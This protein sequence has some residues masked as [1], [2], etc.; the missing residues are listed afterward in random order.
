LKKELF[1]FAVI[2]AIA[3]AIAGCST[4]TPASSPGTAK[5]TAT[6]SL[7]KPQP[8]YGG[9]LKFVQ[10]QAPGTP[11]GWPPD[12]TAPA[13]YTQQM[14]L[15]YLL[16]EELDGVTLSPCLAESY[17]L[18]TDI[19]NPSVIFNIRKGVKFHDGSSLNADVVKWNL[20]RIKEN[21]VNAATTEAWKSFDMIDEYTLRVNFNG[22]KNFFLRSFTT[23]VTPIAS[24][25]AFEKNGLDYV[26]WNMVGTGPFK[27]ADFQRDV[28]AKTVKFDDY[29]EKGKPYLS[30][31]DYVYVTDSTTRIAL[32]KS[33]GA[34]IMDL[35]SD[36]R[37]AN[38]LKTTGYNIAIKVDQ[39]D[40]LFPDSKNPD[41]PWA[42]LKVRM[43]AEYAINKEALAKTFGYGFL[44]AA[45]QLPVTVSS[46]FDPTIP[47]R[48]YDL[49]KAKQLLSEA[50]YPNG[51]D[52]KI[53]TNITGNT[54]REVAI[55]SDLA[56]IGIK[57]EL[58]VNEQA[59]YTQLRSVGWKNALIFGGFADFAN[60]NGTLNTF[61]SPNST[62]YV[63]T[64]KPD[65]WQ[66]A[67]DATTQSLKADSS[68]I[69]KCVSMYYD[70]CTCIPVDDRASMYAAQ[71]Y[72]Q[73]AGLGLR[74]TTFHWYPQNVWLNK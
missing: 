69:N 10:V 38:E 3:L 47:G 34:D 4:Q 39:K 6:A 52:T 32:F 25:T 37:L 58:E 43:A 67:F 62:W 33:G 17:K 31:L 2:L 68:L 66:A 41:S 20:E 46:Y 35:Q 30:G 16:I 5:S 9:T 8:K 56:A 40:A 44:N 27:Q 24:R 49:G 73:D 57:A 72:V 53:I 70:D 1:I 11:I 23:G 65:G 54:N 28:V 15:Q 13:T 64:K 51:F 50:G 45:Y 12:S 59:K 74:G 19:N 63:S 22:Y 21:K 42:N 26:R 60:Y 29:W 71:S 18:S 7:A 14:C 36:T 48:K 55:Q 61:F